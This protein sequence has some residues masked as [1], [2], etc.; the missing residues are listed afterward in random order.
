MQLPLK[1]FAVAE[2]FCIIFT[3]PYRFPNTF[4]NIASIFYM[5]IGVISGME[6][7]THPLS[8]VSH[9][10]TLHSDLQVKL[11]GLGVW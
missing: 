2:I 7:K 8:P 6:Y 11:V 3:Y 1:S 9:N 5:K 4:Q 10:E